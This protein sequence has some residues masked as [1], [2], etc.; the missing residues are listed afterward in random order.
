MTKLKGLLACIGL[1]G[2]GSALAT[3]IVGDSLQNTLT[4]LGAVVDVHADQYDKDAMWRVGGTNFAIASLQFEL[5]GYSSQNS[6][7]IYDIQNPNA[8]LTVFSGPDGAGAASWLRNTT[9]NTYCT[10]SFDA[11]GSPS[12]ASFVGKE[13][14]FFLTAGSGDTFYSRALH[15]ADGVDHLI[16]YQ[17]GEGRGTL[18]DN[19]WLANEFVLAWEDLVGGGDRDYEDFVV[20]VESVIGVPEPGTVT[21]LG[22]G[23]LALGFMTR[24][25][26]ARTQVRS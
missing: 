12:C 24:R 21:T 18:G 20:V 17:G 13:F 7:G 3:P 1:L 9:G 14:G 23:L 8:R 16:A 15:N 11:P 10:G 5:S 25:R 22:M 6:F 2:A 19:P 26:W 4:G